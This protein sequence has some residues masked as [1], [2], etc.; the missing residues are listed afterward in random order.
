MN[1]LKDDIR[2]LFYYFLVPAISSAIAVATYSLI[3][4]IAI[5]Q[6]V[7][8][9]G[10]AACSLVLPIFFIANFIALLCGIGGSVLRNR[11]GSATYCGYELRCW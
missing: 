1:L 8:P 4:T 11:T 10:T 7:G 5:G 6:G 9:D 2:R 3:D